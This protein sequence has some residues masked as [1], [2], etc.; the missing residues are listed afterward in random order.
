MPDGQGGRRTPRSRTATALLTGGWTL[1]GR[2]VGWN[3]G[4][5][6]GRGKSAAGTSAAGGWGPAVERWS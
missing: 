4:Y 3:H 6:V 1:R 2:M 5:R